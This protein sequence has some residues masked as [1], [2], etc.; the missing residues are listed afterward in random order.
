MMAELIIPSQVENGGMLKDPK[1]QQPGGAEAVLVLP[2]VA[3]KQDIPVLYVAG[4]V[5]NAIRTISNRS[6]DFVVDPSADNN[7]MRTVARGMLAGSHSYGTVLIVLVGDLITC[8]HAVGARR[9]IQDGNMEDGEIVKGGYGIGIGNKFQWV[10]I[11]SSKF[12]V[13]TGAHSF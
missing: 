3:I 5:F 13:W 11:S 12:W 8:N 9:N 7:S 1:L 2:V 6:C 4:S 10:G